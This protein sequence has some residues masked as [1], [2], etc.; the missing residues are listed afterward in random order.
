[1]TSGDDQH[2]TDALHALTSGGIPEWAVTNPTGYLLGFAVRDEYAPSGWRLARTMRSATVQRLIDAG[3]ITFGGE[4]L[5]PEY[6]DGRR[7]WRWEEGRVGRRLGL[8]ALGSAVWAF[9]ALA[10]R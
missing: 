10:G 4:G 7:G 1:M 2:L 8:T 9:T 6:D 5:V 3:L